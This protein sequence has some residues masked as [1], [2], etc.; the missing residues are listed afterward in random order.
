MVEPKE[1]FRKQTEKFKS[2]PNYHIEVMK[3][4]IDENKIRINKMNIIKFSHRY[5][6]M[7]AGVEHCESFVCDV[8]V[9]HYCTLPEAFI[10]Y[11]TEFDGGFYKLPNTK[12]L[13]ITIITDNEKWTTVRRYTSEKEKWY[14][15]L[16]GK[17][18]KIIISKT[19]GETK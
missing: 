13:I 9:Q 19:Q 17:N 3:L 18:V 8:Q 16:I 2:D 12:L 15:S 5:K 11:D 4:E 1:W 14:R 10:K 7:P 6:K